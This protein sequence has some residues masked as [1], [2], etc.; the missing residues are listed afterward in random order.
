MAPVAAV[1]DGR[2][3]RRGLR[4]AAITEPKGDSPARDRFPDEESFQK[5]AN[6][7]RFLCFVAEVP[8]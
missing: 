8:A 4:L 1:D 6:A 3:H 2:V 5:F 7:L